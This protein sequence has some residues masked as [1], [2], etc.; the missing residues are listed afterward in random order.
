MNRTMV[1]TAVLA[2]FGISA[3]YTQDKNALIEKL[4]SKDK[5][6]A[7]NAR[8]DLLKLGVDAIPALRDAAAKST[9][10][11]FKKAAV[12]IVERLQVRQAAA[13]LVKTWGDRWYSVFIG[14]VHAG[15]AHMKAEE[16]EGKIVFTEEIHVQTNKNTAFD[17]KADV[18]CNPDEY[19]SLSS[20]SLDIA[21][22]D[23]SV[24]ATAQVKEGRLV[25][26]AGGDVK[27]TKIR[28]NTVVDLAVFPLTTILPRTEG[29][30]IDVMELIKPK[31]PE[32]AVVKFDKEETIDFENRKVKARRFSLSKGD[33][34][35]RFYYVDATN[36]LVR[37]HMTSEDD[38]D[39][40]MTLSDEKRAK[41][42]DTKD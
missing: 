42:I 17:I 2:L 40:E 15:W 22:P 6:E 29:Y 31:L 7:D 27:A 23:K 4:K 20:I 11:D 1:A 21:A 19:L 9:D 25:V 28:P 33:G 13:G 10:E 16:K 39:V 8:E 3:G 32:A 37:V 35:D 26:K 14:T 12:S 30:E 41:D 5:D 36:R 34:K 24:N 38:K 18:T